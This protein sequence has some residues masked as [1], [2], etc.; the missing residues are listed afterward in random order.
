MARVRPGATGVW[1]PL[2]GGV[3]CAVWRVDFPHE[4]LVVKRALARLTVSDDWRAPIERALGE[5]RWFETVRRIDPALAPE[6]VAVDAAGG[7]IAMRWLP[8]ADHTLWKARLLAGDA[9]P[10]FAARVGDALGRIH[11][12]TARRPDLAARFATDEAFFA[13]RLDAYLLTAGRR[14]PDVAGA[15]GALSARTAETRLALVHGDASPKNIMSGPAGPVFLDAETAWYGDPAFDAAFCL[16]HLLL[17]S[18]LAPSFA[19]LAE[20]FDA[21]AAA[22]LARVDWEAPAGAG[23]RAASLLPGLLLARVDGKSP[24]DYLTRADQKAFVRAVALP[25]LERSPR[26]LGQVIAAWR[27]ALARA[28]PPL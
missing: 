11:A 9:D 2:A 19:A 6:P 16:N 21:L 20:S 24:V 17:K 10:A 7:M 5:Y 22:W 8:S 26:T 15:L 4:S 23:A 1:A 3:S 28:K 12:A 14:N 18:L 13:L 25:L 27:A